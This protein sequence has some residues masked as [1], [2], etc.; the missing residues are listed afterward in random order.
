[1]N[2]RTVLILNPPGEE[3]E[4]LNVIAQRYA[5]VV[6]AG[7]AEELPEDLAGLAPA[8]VLVEAGLSRDASLRQLVRAPASLI[9]TGRDE[10]DVRHAA[11]EWPVS[12]HVD[13]FV[14]KPDGPR[15]RGLALVLERALEAHRF[16]VEAEGLRRSLGQQEAKVRD[17]YAE[18]QEIKTL[19][20]ANFI[21]EVEKRISI[22]AKYVWFQKEQQR[23]EAILR[24]IYGADDVSSLLDIVP[25]IRDIVQATSASVYTVEENEVIGRYLKPLVWDGAFLPHSDFS[26]YIT[27]V[28]SQDFAAVVA[29]YGHPAAVADTTGD[30][31]LTRR[32]VEFLKAVPQNLLAV[33]LIQ[34]RKTIGVMEVYNKMSGD[35]IAAEGFTRD[36]QQ[37]LQGLCEHM[38]IAMTK[39]DLIQH[40]ALTGLLRPDPFFDKVLQKINALSKRRREEGVMALVMGDVDWF[41]AYNDRNGQEAGN[42]L[43]RELAHVLR[44]SI[45]EEDLLCRYGGEEFLFFLPGVKGLEAAAQLTD[46]IRKNVEDHYFEFQEFQPQRNLTMSFGVTIFPKLQNGA[47]LPVTKA[48]LKRLAGEA[49]LALAEAKGKQRPDLKARDG[50]E[51]GLSK[52]RVSLYSWGLEADRK[53]AEAAAARERVFRERRKAER[54]SAST[55]V[56]VREAEGYRLAKTVNISLDGARIISDSPLPPA[57]TMEFILVLGEKASPLRSDVVYSDKADSDAPLYYSGLRFRDMKHAD[58]KALEEYLDHFRRRD[59]APGA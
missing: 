36:D 58:V 39:L 12:I 2:S 24:R 34:D 22:E 4:R 30:R 10:A 7:S 37:I 14:W 26:K 38:A 19:I 51:A 35:K 29:R 23:I 5:R 50:G 53:K 44:L 49:D 43:L 56:M 9:I 48:D 21:R 25:E 46:R 27:L 45:R 31:R 13:T 33:P 6:V 42:R 59:A 28:D 55:L 16:R 3:L 52:N 18:I 57:T 15:E 17:V 32:Y 47:A 8:A 54:T 1:M 20:N 40:D 41:K 11:E